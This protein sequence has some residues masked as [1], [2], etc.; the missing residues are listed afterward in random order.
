MRERPKGDNWGKYDI[1]RNFEVGWKEE[2]KI[3][4]LSYR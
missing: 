4:G 2:E 3:N 1:L